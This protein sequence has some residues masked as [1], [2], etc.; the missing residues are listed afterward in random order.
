MT[1]CDNQIEIINAE[2]RLRIVPS[3]QCTLHAVWNITGYR[4]HERYSMRAQAQFPN[5][6]FSQADVAPTPSRCRGG[7]TACKSFSTPLRHSLCVTY[8]SERY[9]EHSAIVILLRM[10]QNIHHK[11]NNGRRTFQYCIKFWYL[12]VISLPR[13]HTADMGAYRA[14]YLGIVP[15]YA[16]EKC[17]PRYHVISPACATRT[18]CTV[19][20]IALHA[21]AVPPRHPILQTSFSSRKY[22]FGFESFAF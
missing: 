16:G 6:K 1:S 2:L 11:C 17:T 20:L 4:Q 7:S 5:L 18:A 13:R 21:I 14:Q 22:S 12:R 15:R 9:P 10:N 3:K 8:V 19:T